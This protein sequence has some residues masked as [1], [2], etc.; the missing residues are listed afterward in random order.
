MPFQCP[1][2]HFSESLP[3]ELRLSAKRLLGDQRVRADRAHM[4]LVFHQVV[5]LEHINVSH[6]HVLVVALAGAAV[7]HAHLAVLRIS[8][9]LELVLYIFFARSRK[10]RRDG[11]VSEFFGRDAQMRFE[12]LPQVHTRCD[13]ER[14]EHNIHRRAVCEIW[15]ILNWTYLRNDSFVSVATRE[16]VSRA[17]FTKLCHFYLY[18]L[19]HTKVELVSPLS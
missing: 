16:F 12:Y 9:L 7:I 18:A 19:H 5:E 4:D 11:A 14:I 13:T 6:R 1:H 3:S 15:H 17:D 10:Y 2:L 8:R